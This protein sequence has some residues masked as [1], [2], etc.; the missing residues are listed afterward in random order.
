M[1]LE[2]VTR[3]G[4]LS[5]VVLWRCHGYGEFFELPALFFF[6]KVLPWWGV[7]AISD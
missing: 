1:I 5:F 3:V 2:N 6:E 7:R 4:K